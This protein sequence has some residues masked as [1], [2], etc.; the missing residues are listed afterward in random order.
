MR[1]A[2]EVEGWNLVRRTDQFDEE[3][4][5]WAF[6]VRVDRLDGGYHWSWEEVR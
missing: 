1:W 5:M 6:E 4:G 3:A 2:D